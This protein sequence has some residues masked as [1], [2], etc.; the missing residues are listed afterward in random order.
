MKKDQ[1]WDSLHFE[2]VPGDGVAINFN[3]ANQ[4]TA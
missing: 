4:Q 1:G 3:L 2:V